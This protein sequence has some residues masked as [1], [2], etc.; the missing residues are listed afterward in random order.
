MPTTS[1]EKGRAPTTTV[2]SFIVNDIPE[3]VMLPLSD[4]HPQLSGAAINIMVPGIAFQ[5]LI[6]TIKIVR[7]VFLSPTEWYVEGGT[8]PIVLQSSGLSLDFK[9]YP[10]C[11]IPATQTAVVFASMAICRIQD[12]KAFD[13]MSRKIDSRI[14]D[15]IARRHPVPEAPSS[16]FHEVVCPQFGCEACHRVFS[17]SNGKAKHKC[18]AEQA[19]VYS[20]TVCTR[21]YAS[22][23]WLHKHIMDVHG[24]LTSTKIPLHVSNAQANPTARPQNTPSPFRFE[25]HGEGGD[26]ATED[27]RESENLTPSPLSKP[28]NER[29]MRSN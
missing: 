17:G 3:G 22:Q 21:E 19:T 9:H 5:L 4:C 24:G 25:Q 1:R 7:G 8:R 26:D 14:V 15:E 28:F 12:K 16:Q 13:D 11:H 29:T 18:E 2:P 10:G 27:L 23:R 6:G 20:C